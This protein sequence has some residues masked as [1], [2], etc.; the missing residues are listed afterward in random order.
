MI[1]PGHEPKGSTS[2]AATWIPAESS[3]PVLRCEGFKGLRFKGLRF[4]RVEVSTS[5]S[6][7]ATSG[8]LS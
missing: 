7:A 1:E 2:I 6:N 5:T 8:I 4:K 3:P